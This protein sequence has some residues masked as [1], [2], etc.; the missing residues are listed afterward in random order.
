MKATIFSKEL[1]KMC[2]VFRHI[3]VRPSPIK[4]Y[5][6]VQIEWK[7]D[8]VFFS[9]R[10]GM[11]QFQYEVPVVTDGEAEQFLIPVSSLKLFGKLCKVASAITFS[12]ENGVLLVG[13]D[14]QSSVEI[15]V[16]TCSQDLFQHEQPSE[17]LTMLSSEELKRLGMFRQGEFTDHDNAVLSREILQLGDHHHILPW[18]RDPFLSTKDQFCYQ[19]NENVPRM[20]YGA[21]IVEHSMT[22]HTDEKHMILFFAGEHV[23]MVF[24]TQEK[25]IVEILSDP[26]TPTWQVNTKDLNSVLDKIQPDKK[27]YVLENKLSHGEWQI[28]YQDKLIK[29]KIRVPYTGELTSCAFCCNI[30]YFQDIM[31][32]QTS[33]QLCF[34]LDQGILFI[35]GEHT[36]EAKL[37]LVVKNKG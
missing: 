9:F 16:F 35:K 14:W 4:A 8:R 37:A 6:M 32:G 3:P 5:S 19:L 17:L 27:H 33:E 23:K 36:P 7:K 15:S 18:Y 21:S 31:K 34:K 13:T 1:D 30:R 20:I 25:T 29:Q 12:L 10:S 24:P 11:F 28:S 26:N 2:R 22:V